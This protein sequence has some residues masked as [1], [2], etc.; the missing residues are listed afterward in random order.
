MGLPN[1]RGEDWE[2]IHTPLEWH[3]QGLDFADALH[4]AGSKACDVFLTFDDKRFA[5]KAGRLG[6][7]PKVQIPA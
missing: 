1:V 5:R 3:V 6:L 4:L 2:Q 7:T